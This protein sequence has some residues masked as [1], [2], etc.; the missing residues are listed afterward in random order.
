MFGICSS[1][2]GNFEASARCTENGQARGNIV[3]KQCYSALVYVTRSEAIDLE[4][5]R[6]TTNQRKDYT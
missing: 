5:H 3:T 1:I 6:R 2:L 4:A